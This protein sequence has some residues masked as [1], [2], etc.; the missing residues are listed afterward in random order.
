MPGYHRLA[1][2]RHSRLAL[3]AAA[4]LVVIGTVV[5]LH[6][7]ADHIQTSGAAFSAPDAPLELGVLDGSCDA[8]RV[9][10]LHDA[11]VRLAEFGI[12]WSDFEPH[13]Q[14]FD[15]AYISK[16]R[17]QFARCRSAGID[18]VLTPGF[19]F[20]PTWVTQLPG[21]AYRD[22]NGDTGPDDVPN[23]VF[24]T[25][26]REAAKR[27]LTRFA[28]EFPL[29]EFAAIRVGTGENGELGYP[30]QGLGAPGN[31][32]WAFDS[33]AQSGQGL[34]EGIPANPM[35]GWVPGE[36]EWNGRQIA[37]ADVQRWFGWYAESMARTIVWEIDLLRSLG[38][39]GTI[40]MPLAGRGALPEDLAAAT[41][42]A[43]DGTGDRD[44][45]LEQGLYYPDQLAFIA[46]ATRADA[47]ARPDA[48]AVDV[49]GV[50]DSTAVLARGLDPPQ[51]SCR[52]S[53]AALPLRKMPGVE[54]WSGFR[55]TAANARANGLQV[56]GENP[57]PPGDGT[58]GDELSDD[59]AGQLEHAP[60]YA[61]ECGL[62]VLFWAFEDNLFAD[63]SGVTVGDFTRRFAQ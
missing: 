10:A 57:G 51:D 62:T 32:F 38:F 40:H 48:V 12:G 28:A 61:R 36:R 47:R 9:T 34:P 15:P 7:N 27:Y 63:D 31:S 1:V 37:T 16:I 23:L 24:S 13:P 30:G 55:W 50:G 49:T 44:G 35:P 4:V 20:A 58:G 45:S 19:H 18:I 59:L 11:G 54:K 60:R 6:V 3:I 46:N 53:D 14:Q 42:A 26:A 2:A 43:L 5:G 8:E 52:E 39:H 22:Q 29:D 25:A 56:V 21:G 41:D 17:D 33:A